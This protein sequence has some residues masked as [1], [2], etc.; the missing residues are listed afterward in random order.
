MNEA[1]F[2]QLLFE[3]NMDFKSILESKLILESS[4]ELQQALQNPVVTIKEK[5]SIIEKLFPESMQSFLKVL[6]DHHK[7]QDFFDIVQIWKE[8]TLFEQNIL[9]ATLYCVTE[10]EKTTIEQ[11]KTFLCQKEKKQRI[12]LEIK[13]DVSLLGGFVLKAGTKEYDRGLKTALK[14]MKKTLCG[15]E[16]A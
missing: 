9:K 7:M 15:G 1:L 12:I 11:L 4:L 8:R 16:R 5:H 3:L 2:A 6:C 14:E 13:K 10:P